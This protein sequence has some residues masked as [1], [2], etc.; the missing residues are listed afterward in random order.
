MGSRGVRSSP[1]L[2]VFVVA[3]DRQHHAIARVIDANGVLLTQTVLA[4]DD[5]W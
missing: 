2:G 5:R 1:P 4:P 3:A